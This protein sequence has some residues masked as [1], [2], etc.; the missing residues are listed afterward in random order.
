GKETSL[1]T[2]FAIM[3]REI[4]EM[5]GPSCHTH[6]TSCCGSSLAPTETKKVDMKQY[7]LYVEIKY[8]YTQKQLFSYRQ[9]IVTL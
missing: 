6:S 3:W 4:V 8:M 2:S 1:S 5:M 7:L 9:Q